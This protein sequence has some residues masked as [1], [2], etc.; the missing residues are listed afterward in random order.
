MTNMEGAYQAPVDFAEWEPAPP[1]DPADPL[2]NA[3][4]EVYKRPSLTVEDL[5]KMAHDGEDVEPDEFE[6]GKAE[7]LRQHREETIG[8]DDIPGVSDDEAYAAYRRTIGE[9]A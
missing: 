4:S 1:G 6:A 7:L 2:K 5:E 3:G 8:G 9:E